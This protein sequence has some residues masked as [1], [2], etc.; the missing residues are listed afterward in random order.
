MTRTI[1]ERFVDGLSIFRSKKQKNLI[2]IT[3]AILF[4]LYVFTVFSAAKVAILFGFVL[5]AFLSAGLL[6]GLANMVPGI[7]EYYEPSVKEIKAKEI[8]KSEK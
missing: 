2:L 1:F 8:L 3:V 7:H 5:S 4:T 6:S